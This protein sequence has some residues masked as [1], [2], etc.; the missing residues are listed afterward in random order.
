MKGTQWRTVS[1]LYGQEQIYQDGMMMKGRCPYCQKEI[2]ESELSVDHIYPL[3]RGGDDDFENMIPCCSRCNRMKADM[4]PD[5]FLEITGG[6][7]FEFEQIRKLLSK[8]R[9]RKQR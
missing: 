8:R 7:L 5:E 1:N 4:L 6:D 3:S 2:R 9:W